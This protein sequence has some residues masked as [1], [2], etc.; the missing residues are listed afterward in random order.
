[1]I[2]EWPK[3]SEGYNF[4]AEEDEMES[5]MAA[6][7]AIRTLRSERNVP[8]SKRPHLIAV[9]DKVK[10]FTDGIPFLKKLAYA[11]E[12]EITGTVPPN[13]GEMAGAVTEDAKLYIP[14]AELVDVEKELER[15]NRELKKAEE[16]YVKIEA[17]LQSEGFIAKAPE[18]VVNAE[19]DKA[20]KLKALIE[21]LKDSAANLAKLSS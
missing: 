13:S 4:A 14:M 2:S 11:G 5:I 12:V 6:I 16:N 9:P 20:E 10:T 3:Y 19:K 8:P 17:K 21:N 1:M 18:A 15:I 7:K